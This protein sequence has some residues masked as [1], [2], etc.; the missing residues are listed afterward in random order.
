MALPVSFSLLLN[1]A[2]LKKCQLF[3]VWI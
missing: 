1:L 3:L 2:V